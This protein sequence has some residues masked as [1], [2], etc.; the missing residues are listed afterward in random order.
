MTKIKLLE[1]CFLTVYLA[2]LYFLWSV[3]FSH[4]VISNSL[5]THGLH[6]ACQASLFITSSQSLLKLMSIESVMPSN[7]LI[8]H[9]PFSYCLRSFPES[10]SFPM[11]QFFSTSGQ[12][13]GVSTLTSVLPKNIQDW[14]TWEFTG[15]ISLQSKELSRVFSN[16]MVQKHK[17]LIAQ[18]SLWSNSHIHTWLLGIS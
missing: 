8:L 15:L 18:H 14:F 1:I 13:I 9:Q 5:Q 16:T 12:S 3:Q 6:E 11:S 10:E 17:F 2:H 7:H 4:S